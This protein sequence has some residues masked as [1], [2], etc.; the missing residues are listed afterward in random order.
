MKKIRV[1]Y[2]DKKFET[3]DLDNIGCGISI[4]KKDNSIKAQYYDK[5][6]LKSIN[7]KIKKLN[8]W[9]PYSETCNCLL[10]DGMCKCCW[11]CDIDLC[12]IDEKVI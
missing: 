11:L 4:N 5:T 3:L 6:T 9:L 1:F 7:R 10:R 8:G 12:P 2:D